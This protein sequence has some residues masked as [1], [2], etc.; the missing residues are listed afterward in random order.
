MVFS[1]FIDALK[2]QPLLVHGTSSRYYVLDGER[3][4][5]C[6]F[7]IG[8]SELF[9]EHQ[10]IFLHSLGV[11]KGVLFRVKQ[12]HGN[13]VY[14][15]KDANICDS[16][17]THCE[18]DAIITHVLDCPIMVLTA[19][20]V[21]I[22]IYDPIRHVAGIVHAGRI[23]TQKQILTKTIEALS[24][25]YDSNPKDLIVG[26]GPAIRGCCYE[27]DEPCAQPFVKKSASYLEFVKK[28][29]KNKFYLDLPQINRIE[30]YEAGVLMNNIHIEGPCTSCENYRWYSYRKEG[31]TGRLMT[32]V[33]LQSRK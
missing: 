8:T 22:I 1:F 25:E 32:M 16:K 3:K 26:M 28:T 6:S 9:L 27:V 14:V 31:R 10:K 7:E 18:A 30:G 13:H 12:V 2:K 33:M 21:P 23:G 11:E 19:D 4:M 15:L 29:L 20:C 5:F 17:D 24:R